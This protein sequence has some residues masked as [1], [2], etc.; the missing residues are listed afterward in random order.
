MIGKKEKLERFKLESLKLDSFTEV[1]KSQAKLERTERSWKEPN[2]VG[3]FIKER[4]GGA[5]ESIF[6]RNKE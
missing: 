6:Y 3:M 5:C 4:I 1:G 2:E